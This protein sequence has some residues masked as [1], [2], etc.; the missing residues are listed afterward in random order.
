[1]LSANEANRRYFRGA[2]HTG[3]HGWSVTEPD[4]YAVRFL[5]RVRGWIGASKLRMRA[6]PGLM[7]DRRQTPDGKLLDVGCGEGRHAI[8]AAR[9]GF[10]V[11]AVDYEPM[12]LQRA[13][14]FA[15]IRRVRGIVFRR[16]DVL[17]LPFPEASFGV[18]LDYG[19]LHHQRKSDWPAYRRSILRVLEPWGFYL[20]SVFGRK[21][22]LFRRSRRRW[23]IAYGAYRR[24]FT[25]RD[26]RGL[27]GRD[28]EI[29]ALAEERGKGGGFWHVLMRRRAQTDLDG[30]IGVVHPQARIAQE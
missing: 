16:A 7:L 23:H 29:V 15:R 9:L 28:F 12:A 30:I 26:I 8:A 3:T 21:F 17:H 10:K 25:P 24:W 19:C 1:M 11:T 14:K 13:N 22:R 4:P 27:F 18:V 6:A 2:Y 20:L 5:K